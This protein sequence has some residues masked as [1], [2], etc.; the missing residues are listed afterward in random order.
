MSDKFANTISTTFE[1]W[2]FR[3]RTPTVRPV[4]VLLMLHGWTGDENSMWSFARN[5]PADYWLLAPRAPYP[6][7]INGYS[8]RAPAP[9]GS[10]PTVETMRPAAAMLKDFLERWGI[11]NS[12]DTS[13]V[14]VIGFSQGGAMTALMG[15]LYPG[16]VRKMGVLAGFVPAGADEFVP[17]RPL[18]GKNIFVAHGTKDEMVPIDL[19][20][21][22]MQILEQ[23]GAAIHYCEAEI[24][25]KLSSECLR[26]LESYLSE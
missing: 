22:S 12:V 4:R 26:A 21:A 24:G 10:W 3:F 23:C 6:A 11:A 7:T 18:A 14:D 25:H 13:Q 19:A 2:T 1:D 5:L 15:L 20:R 17:L 8:W 16:L 9:R